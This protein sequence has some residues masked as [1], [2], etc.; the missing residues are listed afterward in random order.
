MAGVQKI[1]LVNFRN[2]KELTLEFSDRSTVIVG[3]NTCGKTNILESLYLV[4]VGK[5]FKARLEEEMIYYSAASARVS[6]RTES[7]DGEKTLEVFLGRSGSGLPHK[8]L[9]VN[10][11]GKRLIDFAFQFPA[12][13]F[14][15][16]DLDLVTQSPSLRRNFLNSVL[17]GVDREYRRALLSYERGLRQ[18]NRLLVQIRD[19]NIPRSS[20]MFWDELLIKNGDYMLRRREEFIE[21]INQSP[22]LSDQQLCLEYDRSVISRSRLDQYL[23]EEIAAGTTLV[24]PHRDDLLIKIQDRDL[25]KYGSRGEQRMGVL[26]LKLAE[27]SFVEK[28]TGVRPTLLLDDIFSELDHEHR[29]IVLG[30]CTKQ[31][32]IITTADPH[33]TEELSSVEIIHLDS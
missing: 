4:S 6:A 17:S 16:W 13:L 33:Y 30:A 28:I 12:V 8:K 10:G 21:Y 27:L 23:H 3:P 2:F 7:G 9:T 25:A 11:V 19:E 22:A 31:Q 14:G 24:G 32:T 18:R 26:W 1:K 29:R 5:S 20:L 15:P